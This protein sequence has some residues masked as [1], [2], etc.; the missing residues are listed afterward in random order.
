MQRPQA[1]PQDQVGSAV[2]LSR[3]F[4]RGRGKRN[5]GRCARLARDCV[6]KRCRPDLKASGPQQAHC[7][8]RPGPKSGRKVVEAIGHTKAYGDKT[9]LRPF[10]ITIQRGDRIAG[11]AN[12]VG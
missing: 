1:E 4:Q 7:R 8:L 10:D 6:R 5:Q 3:V 12:G 11:R 2:G 9:I